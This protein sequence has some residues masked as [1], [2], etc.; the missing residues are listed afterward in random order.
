MLVHLGKGH[1]WGSDTQGH[2]LLHPDF[3]DSPVTWDPVSKQTKGMMI[4]TSQTFPQ[5]TSFIPHNSSVR[6]P[7]YKHKKLASSPSA[8]EQRTQGCWTPRTTLPSSVLSCFPFQGNS[9]TESNCFWQCFCVTENI[10]SNHI[11]F[12]ENVTKLLDTGSRMVRTLTRNTKLWAS[13]D[14]KLKAEVG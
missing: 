8:G 14:S 13:Q 9:G 10:W 5:R 6:V 12:V 4:S 1:E 2:P 3:E 11:P 7:V